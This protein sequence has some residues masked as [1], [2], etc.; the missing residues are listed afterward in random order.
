MWE[1]FCAYLTGADYYDDDDDDWACSESFTPKERFLPLPSSQYELTSW[2][3]LQQTMVSAV[4]NALSTSK[5]CQEYFA[6]AVVITVGFDDGDLI[7]IK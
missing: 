2:E 5:R 3:A 7:R 6:S 4:S 1:G